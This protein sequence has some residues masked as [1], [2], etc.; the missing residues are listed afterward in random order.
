MFLDIR[1][2]INARHRELRYN[3]FSRVEATIGYNQIDSFL[4]NILGDYTGWGTMSVIKSR[5]TNSLAGYEHKRA[6]KYKSL[7]VISLDNG[8][9]AVSVKHNQ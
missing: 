5:I 6:T 4:N 3:I 2:T 8:T 7:G 9:I 1:L